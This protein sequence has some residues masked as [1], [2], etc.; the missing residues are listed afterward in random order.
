MV[1]LMPKRWSKPDA[2][3]ASRHALQVVLLVGGIE[4]P[5]FADRTPSEERTNACRLHAR[6]W[7]VPLRF[8]RQLGFV[9]LGVWLVAAAVL[10]LVPGLL[11]VLGLL[12]PLLQLAAGLLI[13]I[14]R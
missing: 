2:G 5:W 6:G 9:L 8:N 7:T 3:A 14:G 10:Q 12:M 11:G 1:N 13:L 4:T